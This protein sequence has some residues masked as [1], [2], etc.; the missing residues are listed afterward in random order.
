MLMNVPRAKLALALCLLALLKCSTA[1]PRP[2]F[3]L[4]ASVTGKGKVSSSSSVIGSIS[5]A[6]NSTTGNITLISDNQ[7]LRDVLG[8]VVQVADRFNTM[9][10]AI[11][12]TI[13]SLAQDNSGNVTG[14]FGPALS[15][16]EAVTNYTQNTLP[17]IMVTLQTMIQKGLGAKFIDSFQHIGK[18]LGQING[19]LTTLLGK[20][21]N[22]ILQ[23][24]SATVPAAI[25]A[26]NLKPTL[27]LALYNQLKQLKG[28]IPVLQYTVDSS[29][30]NVLVADSFLTVLKNDIDQTIG[31][32]SEL[33][34]PLDEPLG[35]INQTISGSVIGKIGADLTN[36]SAEALLLTNLTTV[37]SGA[38]L[39][40]AVQQYN[41]S[42][43][44]FSTKNPS[45]PALLEGVRTTVTAAF[46]ILD[47]LVNTNNGSLVTLLISTLVA[48]DRYSRYC[49]HKYKGYFSWM[50]AE[51]AYEASS[52]IV[53][54]V[55]RLQKYQ[56]TLELILD[57]LVYDY[58]D[59]LGELAICNG[60]ASTTNRGDC[61]ALLNTFYQP[62]AEAFGGKLDLLYRSLDH[63]LH[64]SGYRMT[65]CIRVKLFEIDFAQDLL[66]FEAA[67]NVCA[68]DGPTASLDYYL[69]DN[70]TE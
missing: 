60:I 47:P 17:G 40:S 15:A 44:T 14:A 43:I 18:A 45:V 57:T 27:V 34:D 48:N 49:F 21:Q 50:I 2:D 26:S 64:A 69:T 6:V 8:I 1:E 20:A 37:P 66:D 28:S 63:E 51:Y 7:L 36:L 32:S 58:E 30:E 23:A 25:V 39:T 70:T 68:V 31:S 62:L 53:D 59:V 35:A 38:N 33:L 61:V 22:A 9:G 3:A 41:S 5:T 11:S 12:S 10:S 54:E 46:G 67:L 52:C 65:V 13:V 55:P 16:V 29:I 19:T 42:L 24:G 4:D 56:R